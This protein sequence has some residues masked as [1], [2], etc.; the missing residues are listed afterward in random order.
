MILKR[1]QRILTPTIL[2]DNRSKQLNVSK[3]LQFIDNKS[4]FKN[5]ILNS[6]I[7]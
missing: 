5:Y 4:I 3:I 6:D 7:E 1:D 2:S